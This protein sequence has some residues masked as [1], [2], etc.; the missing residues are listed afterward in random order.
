MERHG[1]V[2]ACTDY[3][4]KSGSWDDCVITGPAVLGKWGMYRYCYVYTGSVIYDRETIG[5]VQI[6]DL[7][8]RNDYALWL[9]V[10]AKARCYRLPE[11]LSFYIRHDGSLSSGNKLKLIRWFYAL[12]RQGQG[13]GPVVSS[14]LTL[15]NLF[16]GVL[17]RLLC[18][19]ALTEEDRRMKEETEAVCRQTAGEAPRQA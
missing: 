13:F 17:K 14:L 12:Y 19:R 7:K 5:L 15:D 4:R 2:F 1:Y 10:V 9:K 8:K 11:C 16:F 3:R 6:A 18:K